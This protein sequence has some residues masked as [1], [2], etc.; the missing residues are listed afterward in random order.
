MKGYCGIEEIPGSCVQPVSVITIFK[1][2]KRRKYFIS[3]LMSDKNAMNK[4]PAH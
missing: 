3:L 1:C 2:L 4:I